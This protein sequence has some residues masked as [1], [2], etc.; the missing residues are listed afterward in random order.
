[1]SK[2]IVVI[3]ACALFLVFTEKTQSKRDY[4]VPR[5]SIDSNQMDNVEGESDAVFKKQSTM[6][7]FNKCRRRYT[8]TTGKRVSH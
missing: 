3:V 4:S 6:C 8:T 7:I 2:V 5:T 1:M